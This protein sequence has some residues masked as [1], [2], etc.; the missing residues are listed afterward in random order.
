LRSRFPRNGLQGYGVVAENAAGLAN[1][2]PTNPERGNSAEK[3]NG[4]VSAKRCF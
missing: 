3:L 2:A 1:Q 4:I